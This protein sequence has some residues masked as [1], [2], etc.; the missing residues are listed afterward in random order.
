MPQATLVL[1][2]H[3]TAHEPHS[4]AHRAHHAHSSH[5]PTAHSPSSQ[6]QSPHQP[7]YLTRY[8]SAH[9]RISRT[10]ISYMPSHL[11][12]H[13]GLISLTASSATAPQL[14]ATLQPTAQQLRLHLTALHH[15][16]SHTASLPHS[17]AHAHTYISH[18]QLQSS[19]HPTALRILQPTTASQ[20][21]SPRTS[22]KPT[23]PTATATAIAYTCSHI[24]SHKP[25]TSHHAHRVTAHSLLPT[26]IYQPNLRQ[27]SYSQPTAHNAHSPQLAPLRKPQLTLDHPKPVTAHSP[28]HISAQ[29]SIQ[30]DIYPPAQRSTRHT[31]LLTPPRRLLIIASFTPHEPTSHSRVLV[32]TPAASPAYSPQPTAHSTN[33]TAYSPRPFTCPSTYSP[34][35]SSRHSP[36]PTAAHPESVHESIT[37]HSGYSP[38]STVSHKLTST[39]ANLQP[40]AHSSQPTAHSPQPTAYSPPSQLHQL[41]PSS[42]SSQP[43]SYAA[44]L[45]CRQLTP[46][47][48]SSAHAHSSRLQPSIPG[49]HLH[50]SHLHNLQPTAHSPHTSP[51]SRSSGTAPTSSSSLQPPRHS[52]TSLHIS[53]STA[54]SPQ[55]TAHSLQPTAHSPQPTAHSPQPT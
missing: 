46:T 20:P 38:Q 15:S 2:R 9:S 50:I 39:T 8:S 52:S 48:H 27:Q 21:I 41:Q 6:P 3:P 47:R 31:K 44:Q 51:T 12:H 7:N 32:A 40:T 4:Q 5:S 30:P 29:L 45:T 37:S 23:S 35:S 36:H 1:Q 17:P 49:L 16:P 42:P 11:A 33:L 14:T 10:L 26:Y 25:L 34:T 13:T 55:P 24:P 54:H 28:S 53:S 43:Y 22:P 18:H 19:P